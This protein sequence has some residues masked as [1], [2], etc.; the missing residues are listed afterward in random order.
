MM[1]R[2]D[3]KQVIALYQEGCYE[4]AAQQC[5]EMVRVN[6][7]DEDALY[8]QGL[9]AYR[10]GQLETAAEAM[11]QSVA[12]SPF[13]QAERI[14][15]LGQV[16]QALGQHE[17]AVVWYEEAQALQPTSA[18]A[19]NMA[20]S[21]WALERYAGG[22]EVM[23][24]Y[25]H[26]EPDNAEG[27]FILSTF[28]EVQEKWEAAIQSLEQ[29]LRLRSDY[30]EAAVNLGL[31]LHQTRHLEEATNAFMQAIGTNPNR[32]EAH[33]GLGFVYDAQNRL[34]EAAA[35]YAEAVRHKPSYTKALSNLGSALYRLGRLDE[36]AAC[37]ENAL[38]LE[39]NHAS[40][41][42]NRS[43]VLLAQGQ[44]EEGWREYEWRWESVVNHKAESERLWD[45]SSL[46]GRSLFLHAEQGFGDTLQFVRYGPLLQQ[47]GARVLLNCK[48]ALKPL[49]SRCKGID[50][51]V[52]VGDP[53]PS[54]DVEVPLMS[55]P[56]RVGTTLE[57]IPQDVPYLFADPARV[58]AWK[59]RVA[60]IDG[61]KVGIAWQGSTGYKGDV[62]R[63]IPLRHF[64]SLCQMPGL[65]LIS[66][67]KGYGREQLAEVGA[68]QDI[69][70]FDP[71]LDEGVG[72][73]E[74]TAALM[75]NLDLVITS[76]TA[77]AHL[78]GGLGV[79]VWVALPYAADWRWLLDR[80]DSPWY[81]T[82]RLFRQRTPGDW[83]EVFNRIADHIDIKQ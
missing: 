25:V 28:Q 58:E 74:D 29:A 65:S 41:R 32:A 60:K 42:F 71:I 52:M 6:P 11:M 46:D 17:E 61:F 8:V 36:A 31:L 23:I 81:P 49:L 66:M 75:M 72:A 67:Q 68:C 26:D 12:L 10:L 5:A 80:D 83:A 14:Q 43:H 37:Y 82:M 3:L 57:T 39:P 18:V 35:C 38:A 44:Y 69:Y 1:S 53:M 7:L 21:L 24:T 22:E 47:Q 64:A 13:P 79:P 78:A 48:P 76:D 20:K 4:E 73:F 54:Y 15:H 34:E 50:Q 63:S 27:F 9:I 30:Y 62:F 51:L 77:V 16:Y 55:V 70:D 40:A 19:L 56:G 33:Q 59:E 2:P 45:G